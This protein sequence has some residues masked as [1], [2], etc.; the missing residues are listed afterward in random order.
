MDAA[1]AAFDGTTDG[2]ADA[3]AREDSARDDV[4]DVLDVLDATIDTAPTCA[5]DA[6]LSACD[7]A[8]VDLSS[9][10]AN[11]G[12][13]GRA[14]SADE[15]CRAARCEPVCRIAGARYEA[16]ERNP[17]NPCE[18]CDP[19]TSIAAW[20]PVPDRT[21]CGTG[22][23]CA[24]SI[25]SAGC[26]IG[27][28]FVAD[29][30]T[31]PGNECRACAA[32]EST[33]AY[34]A[35]TDGA[36]CGRGQFCTAGA[37]GPTWHASMPAGFAPMYGGSA[38]ATSDGRVVLFG[39]VSAAT[40]PIVQIYDPATNTVTR[41]PDAPYV[42]YR[43]CAVRAPSGRIYVMGG[44]S[45]S[46]PIATSAIYDPATNTFSAGP[47]LP[48]PAYEHGCALGNNGR[49]YVFATDDA[50]RAGDLFVTS[51]TY[52]LD[53]ATNTWTTG[54]PMPSPR[55]RTTA[56]TLRDGRIV[57]SGGHR[58]FIFGAIS[59]INEIY[60]PTTNTWTTGAPQPPLVYWNLSALRSDGR[61]VITGGLTT[62][63][64]TQTTHVYDPALDRWTESTPHSEP[65]QAGYMAATPDGR[66]Y[67]IGGRKTGSMLSDRVEALY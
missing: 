54:A 10:D 66:L 28:A 9:D 63:G 16:D 52:I 62:D 42:P 35:R 21:S 18:R 33:S 34:T 25:C 23:F 8:C 6:G 53:P 46:T 27:G 22:R 61:V 13:C 7:G 67:V 39:G 57:V 65:H 5:A 19:A 4:L 17:M 15:A 1:E 48:T 47:A 3:R 36:V 64:F 44:Q 31:E 11:C 40:Q 24:A 14:C 41:G 20:S 30:A 37:C 26:V 59:P 2:A 55:Q 58:G 32:S 51:H 38:A 50:A 60:N 29:G 12:S 43:S 56:V 49:I 45:G